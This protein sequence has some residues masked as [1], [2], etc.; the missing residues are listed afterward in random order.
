MASSEKVVS[1]AMI[2]C[3]GLSE[4][5]PELGVYTQ[6]DEFVAAVAKAVIPQGSQALGEL[7]T[8]AGWECEV[9]VPGSTWRKGVIRLQASLAFTEEDS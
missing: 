9:L 8:E 3:S 1:D 2:R 4:L 7:M 5:S 6:A